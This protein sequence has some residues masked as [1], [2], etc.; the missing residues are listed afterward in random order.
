MD[1]RA[2]IIQTFIK[3][4]HSGI[5]V[6]ASATTRLNQFLGIVLQFIVNIQTKIESAMQAINVA[7]TPPLNILKI[8]LI[9]TAAVICVAHVM[10]YAIE[11]Y[12]APK[13]NVPRT[14]PHL[15]EGQES[16]GRNNQT[17]PG[18]ND[19]S[20][21]IDP[22][23]RRSAE[24]SN[25]EDAGDSNSQR[26]PL[27]FESAAASNASTF[28]NNGASTISPEAGEANRRTRRCGKR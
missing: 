16:E 2:I 26:N 22:E 6:I 17:T 3:K 21:A 1:F 23:S 5:N 15:Q 11:T 25:G 24:Q 27:I 4:V 13:K 28:A 10:V 8:V 19:R 9:S 7:I 14:K 18:N 12:T 20:S